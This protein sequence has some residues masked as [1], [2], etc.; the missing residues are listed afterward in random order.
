MSKKPMMGSYYLLKVVLIGDGGVG[1]TS[2]CRRFVEKKFEHKYLPTI[3][4][5]FYV[6]NVFLDDVTP[7]KFQ[8]WDLAGQPRFHSVVDMYFRG[9]RGALAVY[10]V[11]DRESYNNLINWVKRLI[12]KSGVRPPPAIMI[13]GNKIDLRA[14]PGEFVSPEEGELLKNRIMKEF[15]LKNVDFLET[16]AKTGENVIESFYRLAKMALSMVTRTAK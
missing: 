16:S 9:A 13:L 10:S 7:V 3:G 5:D 8:I 14:G 12:E 2:L 4:A 6:K 11:V 1:K 15:G